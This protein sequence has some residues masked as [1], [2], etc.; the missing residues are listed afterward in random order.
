MLYDVQNRVAYWVAY[1][2]SKDYLGSQSRTDDW[3]YDPAFKTIYQPLLSK[4]FGINGIDRGHQIPSGD[5]TKNRAENATTF[6][7]TNMTPQVSSMNQ[8]VWAK[9][10]NKI[11]SWTT[12]SG[13]DTMYVVT[14]A[15]IKSNTDSKIDYVQDNAGKPVAKPKYYYKALAMKRG[16]EYYTIG[17]KINNENINTG[18]D[19]ASY[20]MTVS[21]LEKETGFTFFPGLSAEKKQ[22][23]NNAFWR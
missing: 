2:L 8:G 9:L 3:G 6:Y 14:G 20:R 11:R 17:F 19:P 18:A 7:Y 15:A 23:I 21:E 12:S 5:R 16:S 4:G 13:V 22:T 1:P 10:E